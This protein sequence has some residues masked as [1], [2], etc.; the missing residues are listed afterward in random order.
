VQAD[1]LVRNWRDDP[2]VDVSFVAVDP[3]FPFG[4]GWAEQVPVLRTILREPLYAWKLWRGL[5]DVDVAHITSSPHR[6]HRFSW[7]PSRRGSR[8]DFWGRRL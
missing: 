5:K 2:D 8:R 3:N 6:I 4:L 1:L 7:P